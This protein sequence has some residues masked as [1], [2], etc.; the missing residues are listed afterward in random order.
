MSKGGGLGK[1]IGGRPAAFYVGHEGAGRVT[2]G[3]ALCQ[4]QTGYYYEL[5]YELRSISGHFQGQGW[6]SCLRA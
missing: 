5:E 4:L 1:Q 2:Q 3:C 6:G